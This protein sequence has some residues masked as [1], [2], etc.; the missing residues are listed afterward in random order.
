MDYV[1]YTYMADIGR[2]NLTVITVHSGSTL[3][4][5]AIVSP[6]WDLTVNGVQFKFL[7]NKHYMR[8]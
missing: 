4:Y 2:L 7:F 3:C 5:C 8:F 6:K 1:H